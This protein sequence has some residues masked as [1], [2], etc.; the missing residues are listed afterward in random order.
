MSRER[1]SGSKQHSSLRRRIHKKTPIS[2]QLIMDG[3]MDGAC[4]GVRGSPVRRS[5]KNQESGKPRVGLHLMLNSTPPSVPRY[6]RDSPRPSVTAAD[7]LR[8]HRTR[9]SSPHHSAQLEQATATASSQ[10]RRC[11]GR[12]LEMFYSLSQHVWHVVQRFSVVVLR[13][14]NPL[15]SQLLKTWAVCVDF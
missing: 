4:D 2:Y 9:A 12:L 10:R 13:H 3:A 7:L 8:T 1:E 11:D 6:L 14:K 15:A 5:I